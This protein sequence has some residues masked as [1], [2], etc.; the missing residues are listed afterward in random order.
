MIGGPMNEAQVGGGKTLLLLAHSAGARRKD[1]SR[2]WND[3]KRRDVKTFLKN[4]QH[5]GMAPAETLASDEISPTTRP[6]T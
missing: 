6:N 2:S 3:R 4:M 1:G 5:L